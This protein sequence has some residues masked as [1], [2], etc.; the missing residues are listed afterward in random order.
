MLSHRSAVADVMML[1][2]QWQVCWQMEHT[3]THTPMRMSMSMIRLHI[4]CIFVSWRG[5][6]VGCSLQVLACW[7]ML[8]HA[9]FLGL[10]PCTERRVQALRHSQIFKSSAPASAPSF[11]FKEG[12]LTRHP[13][14]VDMRTSV[15]CWHRARCLSCIW[16]TTNADPSNVP[17]EATALRAVSIPAMPSGRQTL[18]RC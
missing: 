11:S 14:H 9:H 17:T 16:Q 15:E 5:Y 4:L 7:P 3:H 2:A 6:G 10:I 18:G 13:E 8:R 1:P 12:P